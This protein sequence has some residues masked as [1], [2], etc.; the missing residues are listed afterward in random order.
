M[1]TSFLV[2]PTIH[3]LKDELLRHSPYFPDL[4]LSDYFL[5]SISKDY[6]K[7]RHHNDQSS[8]GSSIFQCLNSMSE[9]DLT[10]A[11]QKLPERWE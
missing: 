2:S 9:D 4:A 1:Y 6:L 3:D 5:F 8:L 11:V 10:A 7:G